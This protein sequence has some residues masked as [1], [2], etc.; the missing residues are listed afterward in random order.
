MF[1]IGLFWPCSK[2][3]LADCG[4]LRRPAGRLRQ[5]L[6]PLFVLAGFAVAFHANVAAATVVNADELNVTLNGGALFDDSF[7]Q[8]TTLVGGN[9]SFVASGVDFSTGTA[10]DYFVRG[11]IPESSTNNGQATFNTS[12]GVVIGQPPPFL[13]TI[14]ET[15]AFLYSNA[16]A[17]TK[18]TTGTAFTATGLFDLTTPSIVEG[19]YALVLT[20]RYT[21]NGMLGNV[22]QLRVRDCAPGLGLCGSDTGTVLQF[23]WLNYI[24]DTDLLINEVELGSTTDAQLEFEFT[25][26][27]G[28]DDI[29]GSYAT[30]DGN[31]LATFSGT[32]TSLGCTTS[33]TDVFNTTELG[34][35][36][37]EA[38]INVFDPVPEPSSLV[39]MCSVL[40][41]LGP[42]ARSVPRKQ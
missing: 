14:Q 42:L 2:E 25:H 37:V 38:G 13:S 10:A 8:N 33:A 24:T 35:Q 9:G 1:E 22:L 18:L 6:A 15:S 17:A 12:N 11:S 31:T 4:P 32:L 3:W 20:N 7:A 26:A 28:T 39:L 40:L 5:R 29:C 27:L 36:T 21:S 16:T 30:G 19:T 34:G 41:V 23:V